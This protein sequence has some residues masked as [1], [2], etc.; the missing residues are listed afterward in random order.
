MF[1]FLIQKLDTKS[2]WLLCFFGGLITQVFLYFYLFRYSSLKDIPFPS[3]VLV[4]AAISI[5]IVIIPS[6]LAF[7]FK[8]ILDALFLYL[9]HVNTSNFIHDVKS[10][11]FEGIFL[12][13]IMMIRVIYFKYT[14]GSSLQEIISHK[15]SFFDI[16][17]WYILI[18]IIL[19]LIS[20]IKFFYKKIKS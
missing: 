14:Q 20:V 5:N 13:Y 11:I 3:L 4:I 18:I 8:N 9:F 17:Y 19:I 6:I 10:S 15:I 1:A 12:S 16:Y 7:V 2:L